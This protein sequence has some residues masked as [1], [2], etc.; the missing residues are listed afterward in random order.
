MKKRRFLIICILLFLLTL[1]VGAEMKNGYVS[2]L[3]APH[4]GGAQTKI[5]DSIGVPLDASVTVGDYTLKADAVIGDKYNLTIVYSLTRVDG[6]ELSE[7][8]R[9]DDWKS[10]GI[11]WNSGYLSHRI[12][13]DGKTLYL[14][15]KRTG[16]QP[17]FLFKRDF[18]VDFTDLIIW[19]PE[20]AVAYP[21]QEGHWQLR[22]TIRYEDTTKTVWRGKKAIIDTDGGVFTIRK[23]EFSPVGMHMDLDYPACYFND[24]AKGHEAFRVSLLLQDG[25][26]IPIENFGMGGGG[27]SDGETWDYNFRCMFEYPIPPENVRAI[28]ICSTEFEVK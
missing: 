24:V 14:M 25:T 11:R 13:E 4:Y 16:N 18:Q 8:T 21:L 3:L 22:F 17:L 27:K 12:S 5:V 23:I 2:N 1:P 10:Q 7:W 28:V 19:D 9:F 15:E 26:Q 6:K 20:A